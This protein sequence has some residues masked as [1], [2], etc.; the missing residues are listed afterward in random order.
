MVKRDTFLLRIDPSVLL[1]IRKWSDDEMRSIN[2]QI[3]YLLRQALRKAGRLDQESES[4]DGAADA[5][6]HSG[7]SS[8]ED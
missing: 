7:R 4:Q 5:R 6:N 2:G 8:A 1:A 3:E